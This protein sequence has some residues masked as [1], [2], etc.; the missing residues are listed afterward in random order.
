MSFQHVREANRP[1]PEEALPGDAAWSPPKAFGQRIG[2]WQNIASRC[3][4][5]VKFLRGGVAQRSAQPAERAEIGRGPVGYGF[6]AR[7][8]PAADDEGVGLASQAIG[9][10]ID[11]RPSVE[12]RRP[13][14]RAEARCP[15][16]RDYGAQ[17]PHRH[18]L[19]KSSAKR[20]RPC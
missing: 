14:V 9:D 3:Q 16:S 17:Q 18:R 8:V 5:G 6:E 20:K 1:K 7:P 19:G 13:L 10:M 12:Q 4:D 11:Q 2:D 15:A